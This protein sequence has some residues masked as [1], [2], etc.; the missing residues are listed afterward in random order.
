M[1]DTALNWK[2]HIQNLKIRISKFIGILASLAGFIWGTEVA[3]LR[4]IYQAV[5]IPQIIYGCFI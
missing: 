1:L 2:Q 4:K 5:I 3:E